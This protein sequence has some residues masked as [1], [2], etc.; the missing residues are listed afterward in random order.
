MP[1]LPSSGSRAASTVLGTVGTVISKFTPVDRPMSR[2]T[3]RLLLSA[4]DFPIFVRQAG[5]WPAA[6]IC[7]AAIKL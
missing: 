6:Y 4:A 2:F 7:A 3:L 1:A 5:H